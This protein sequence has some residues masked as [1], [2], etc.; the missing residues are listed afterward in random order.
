MAAIATSANNLEDIRKQL[1]I[2]TIG[3]DKVNQLRH[4]RFFKDSHG[5]SEHMKKHAASLRPKFEMIL[6]TFDRELKG[7]D[8]GSWYSPKVG[9]FITYETLEGCAKNVVAKA[10]KAGVTM[11]PAGAPFPYGKDPKDIRDPYLSV[12]PMP[13]GSYD[14]NSDFCCLRKT[15]QHR[16]IVRDKIENGQNIEQKNIP[17]RIRCGIFFMSSFIGCCRGSVL[18]VVEFL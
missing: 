10:Q 18:P 12:L 2:Q 6:E 15:C 16:E 9:Y 3:H 11:T 1:K 13:G 4:V 7:L 17:H 5:I 8:V 14:R